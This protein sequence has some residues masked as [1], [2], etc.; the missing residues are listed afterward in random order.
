MKVLALLLALC[1][2]TLNALWPLIANAKPV[3]IPHDICSANVPERQT[4]GE[5]SG[6]VSNRSHRLL[7]C[8]LCSVSTPSAPASAPR[9]P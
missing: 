3:D 4:K 8:A 6:D 5:N 7:H 2:T 9:F 1:G